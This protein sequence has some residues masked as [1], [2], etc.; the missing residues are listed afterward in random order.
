[1]KININ[2]LDD[3][4]KALDNIDKIRAK[5]YVIEATTKT[6][7]NMRFFAKPHFRTG[8]MERNITH[9]INGLAGVVWIQDDNMLVNWKGK[10]INYANFVLYG[11]KAHEI[12]PKNK[13]SLRS[14]LGG[15]IF[16]KSVQHKGYQGDDFIKKSIDK[17]FQDMIGF[18]K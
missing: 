11:S 12:T 13:K 9:R 17:T 10:E 6:Y 18:F 2:G 15:F 3:T 4:F 8:T 7:E 16:S 14:T 5:E 1:M